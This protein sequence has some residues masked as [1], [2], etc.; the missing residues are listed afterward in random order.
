MRCI[1]KEIYG[2]DAE[3]FKPER[4]FEEDPDR[5]EFMTKASDLLFSKG[6]WQCLGKNIAMMQLNKTIFEVL[7]SVLER[8]LR[9]C[10]DVAKVM[11]NFDIALVNP[12]NPWQVQAPIGLI[13]VED[14]WVEVRAR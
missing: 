12:G 14:L 9:G 6:R 10:A 11:R 1:P 4:W 2:E 13:V 3:V 8:G 7:E 5:L